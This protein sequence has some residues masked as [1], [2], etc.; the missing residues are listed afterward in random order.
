MNQVKGR[1]TYS[2][3]SMTPLRL[4][5]RE[6]K[7]STLKENKLVESNFQLQLLFVRVKIISIKVL[8]CHKLIRSKQLISKVTLLK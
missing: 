2:A 4:L 1:Y 7:K 8:K 6:G 5:N 3:N